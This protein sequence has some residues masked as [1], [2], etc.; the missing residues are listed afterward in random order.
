[1]SWLK[2]FCVFICWAEPCLKSFVNKLNCIIKWVCNS[3]TLHW[4]HED[5]IC[6]CSGKAW[7]TVQGVCICAHV[8]II[9]QGLKR[10]SHSNLFAQWQTRRKFSQHLKISKSRLGLRQHAWRNV[11]LR[12]YTIFGH[13]LRNTAA[14][15]VVMDLYSSYVVHSCQLPQ[16]KV[17]LNFSVLFAEPDELTWLSRHPAALPVKHYRHVDH[18]RVGATSSK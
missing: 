3:N 11:W 6:W 8:V 2:L 17:N 5:R 14:F 16:Y 15:C 12:H 7:I 13:S 10:C 9:T 4:W 18:W 1:M